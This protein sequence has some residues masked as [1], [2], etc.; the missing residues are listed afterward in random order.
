[1]TSRLL[2]EFASARALRTGHGTLRDDGWPVLEWYAPIP[3]NDESQ[4]AS[5]LSPRS[6]PRT[7]LIA[8]VVCGLGIFGIEY[9][10][11]VV[12]YAI[13]VGGRPT[14]SWIAFVPAMLETALLAAAIG[15]VVAFLVAAR[16]PRFH[17]PLFD[18]D[19]FMRAS[20][21]RYFLLI[22]RP[23]PD[24]RDRDFHQRMTSLDVIAVHE[25]RDDA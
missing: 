5:A 3:M 4:A 18:V 1:M 20:D 22:D 11:A 10:A 19:G 6:I 7:A 15:I 23:P 9:Y 21:N 14:A 25:V 12:D 13:D 17:H 2:L 24:E 8:G 16:L